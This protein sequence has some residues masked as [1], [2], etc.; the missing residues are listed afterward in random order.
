MDDLSPFVIT[1]QYSSKRILNDLINFYF[2]CISRNFDHCLMQLGSFEFVGKDR[3]H[4][5]P[6]NNAVCLG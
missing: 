1:D 6:G 4:V 3:A 2:F 5:V